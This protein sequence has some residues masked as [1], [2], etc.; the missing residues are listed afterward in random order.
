MK[1]IRNIIVVMMCLFVV[2][3]TTVYASN[4]GSLVYWKAT[5]TDDETN[6][7]GK[8]FDTPSVSS[9][10]MTTDFMTLSTTY[11]PHARGQWSSAG[12][13][14]TSVSSGADIKIYGGTLSQLQSIYPS[15]PSTS[16]GR[17]VSTRSATGD[18]YLYQ[19]LYTKYLYE[20]TSAKIYIKYLS[21]RTTSQ[22][23]M[24]VTHELSHALGWSGHS[25]STSDIMTKAVT[26]TTTLQNDEKNH[27][28]QVY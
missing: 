28:S 10:Y 6:V 14:T 17:T 20:Y 8:H 23:K 12:V 25:T 3:G 13:D 26:S 21:L 11:V 1:K 4:L 18:Y 16:A 2:L 15:F 27:L 22:N 9:S 5:H 24:I 7:I 19:Y